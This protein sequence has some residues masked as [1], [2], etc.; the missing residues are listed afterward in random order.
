MISEREPAGIYHVAM[1]NI[2]LHHVVSQKDGKTAPDN[3]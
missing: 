3:Y 1:Q 2:P